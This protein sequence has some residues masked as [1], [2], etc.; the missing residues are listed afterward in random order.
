MKKFF[1]IQLAAG[2]L[3]AGQAMAGSP[4]YNWT[5][6]YVGGYAGYAWGKTE[7]RDIGNDFSNPWYVLGAKFDTK[8]DSFIIGGQTGYNYQVGNWLTGI[9]VD[10]GSLRL[11]GTGLY[12]EG[13]LDTFVTTNSTYDISLRARLGAV[14]GQNLFYITGGAMWANFNSRVFDVSQANTTR[15]TGVQTSWILGGGWEY[16]LDTNWS[17]K[18]EY[19]HYE[20]G[21]DSP[22]I[23]GTGYRF[24]IKNTGDMVRIGF[25]YKFGN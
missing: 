11:K 17:I 22:D 12:P 1:A 3:W 15:S 23:G 2:L 4:A 8:P 21:K 24:A 6:F 14:Y 18:T 5:G 25:N 10:G 20:S 16:A 9:E 7:A 19:L 13:G